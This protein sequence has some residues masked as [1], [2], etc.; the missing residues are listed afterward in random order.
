MLVIKLDLSE[1][2]VK[3]L[4]ELS[5]GDQQFQKLIILFKNR[6]TNSFFVNVMATTNILEDENVLCETNVL[7]SVWKRILLEIWQ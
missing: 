7:K 6:D 1:A 2:P 3:R 4:S 5:L